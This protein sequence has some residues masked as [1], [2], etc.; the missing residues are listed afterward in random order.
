[1]DKLKAVSKSECRVDGWD[2]VTGK[3]QYGADIHLPHMLHMAVLRSPH[4][5]ARIKSIDSG[6][7]RSVNGVFA[8]VTGFDLPGA[9]SFG[10]E[11]EDKPALAFD[12]VR[13]MGDHVALVV[14]KTRAIAVE[15]ANKIVVEYEVLPAVFDPVE[16]LQAGAPQVH[17][18][19]NLLADHDYSVGDIEKGF[20]EADVIVERTFNVQRISPAYLEPEMAVASWQADDTLKVWSCSQMPFSDRA[21]I[22]KIL[23]MPEEKIHVVTPAIGGSFGGKSDS[24]MA[25]LAALGAWAVKGN[26]SLVNSRQES[27]VAYPKR[28]PGVIHYKIGA[29]RDGMLVALNADMVFN[30]GAY[31]SFGPSVGA[32]SAEMATGPYHIP[33]VHSR[34]RVVYTNTPI[35]GSIRGVSGPQTCFVFELAMDMVADKLK[36]DPIELRKKNSWK[37]GGSTY[38]GLE[39]KDSPSLN[40]CLDR[41]K[42]ARE[43]LLRKP[44]TPGKL[45]GVGVASSLLKMGMGR[46]VPDASTNRIEW[47]PG[48]RV[49][50]WLGS[51]D[52]GQGLKTV[53]T[54]MA[55]ELLGIPV[56]D[57]ELAQLDTSV[58]PNGGPT[59]TSRTTLMIGNSLTGA[60]AKAIAA[61]LDFAAS[62]LDPDAKDLSYTEG[63]VQ[64]TSPKGSFKL[65]LAYFTNKA[66]EKGIRLTGEATYEFPKRPDGP[67]QYPTGLPHVKFCFGAHVA[68]VEVDPAL[69]TV[70]VT[71]YVAIHDVGKAINPMSVEGQIEGGVIMG[72]GYAL[73]EEMKLR[74]NGAWIDNLSEYIIPTALDAPHIT[75]VIVEQPDPD[76]PFGSKG[77][78][79]QVTV[80]VAPAIANAVFNATGRRITSLPITPEALI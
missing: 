80:A 13:H 42:D 54:Q 41:A 8:I 44:A 68:R 52:I 79:E 76:G 36:M 37:L 33:N 60:A 43:E 75:A 59:N 49:L 22:A 28:H 34:S 73:M 15:A 19:G 63:N 21:D 1:M 16:A 23:K 20:A 29:R 6:P 46:G 69:G 78:G 56:R 61:L 12:E 30:T 67:A 32:I 39:F 2:K 70:E 53:G 57:I 11:V 48:G 72:L 14:A 45:C 4:H 71:D 64:F 40:I 9:K 65:P 55:A 35:S 17:S 62:E 31:A 58:S 74:P 47:L 38:L 26:V 24:T 10:P 18:A 7:A 27:M 77:L 51:P 25:I 50:L 5:H 66:A 3:A